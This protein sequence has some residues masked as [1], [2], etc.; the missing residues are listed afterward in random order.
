MNYNKLPYLM[1]RQEVADLI[2]MSRYFI[3]DHERELMLMDCRVKWS[4]SRI[5]YKR[6]D[7]IRVFQKQG[8]IERSHN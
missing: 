8:L 7:V 2:G 1:T 3:M 5:R 6:D 4:S